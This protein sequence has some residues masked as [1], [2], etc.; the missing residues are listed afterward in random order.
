MSKNGKGSK[1]RPKTVDNKTWEK[2]WYNIFGK[3]NS[4]KHDNNNKVRKK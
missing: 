4:Q 1:Y 2:N 3:Q